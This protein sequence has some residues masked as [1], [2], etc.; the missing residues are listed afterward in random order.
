MQV[1]SRAKFVNDH[2][3]DPKRV[4]LSEEKNDN[5]LDCIISKVK[6]IHVDPNVGATVQNFVNCQSATYILFL[7]NVLLDFRWTQQPRPN[8]W[9]ALTYTMTCHILLLILHLLTSHQVIAVSCLHYLHMALLLHK[10]V[11][12]LCIVCCC[13]CC[14][15]H[16]LFFTYSSSSTVHCKGCFGFQLSHKP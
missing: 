12:D 10:L 1:I 13:C 14:M 16:T 9:L 4:F 2:T 3:H 8:W 15:F 11:I 5:L 6:I 7:T